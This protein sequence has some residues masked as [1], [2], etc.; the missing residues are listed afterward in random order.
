MIKLINY[1]RHRASPVRFLSWLVI[2]CGAWGC[3]HDSYRWTTKKKNTLDFLEQ[4]DSLLIIPQVSKDK[5]YGY[6]PGNP[7]RLGV[8][9]LERAA[10]YPELFFRSIVGPHQEKIMYKRIRSCCPFKT[11]NSSKEYEMVGVLEVYEISYAGI[12]S[13]VTLYV[14]FFD[15]GRVMIPRGFKAR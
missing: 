13:P 8:S 9:S 3:A 4:K 14:N 2:L 5:T 7:I 11:A 6:T 1:W 15:Q 12:P 10:T